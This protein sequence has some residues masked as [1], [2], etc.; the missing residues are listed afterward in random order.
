MYDWVSMFC[1][2]MR[3]ASTPEV[4]STSLLAINSN[5]GCAKC[6]KNKKFGKRSCCA[7]GGAWFKNC[8]DADDRQFDHTWAEGIQ[9][10]K[11]FGSLVSVESPLQVMFHHLGV[12]VYPVNSTKSR[13]V[14]KKRI[15]I[16][17][18]DN[19]SNAGKTDSEDCITIAKIVVYICVLYITIN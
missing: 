3:P 8:G 12:D 6:G 10:C 2:L 1:V 14:I 17:R 19:V 18:P 13:N 5:N 9:A 15:A 7:R 16:D 4:P 11:G